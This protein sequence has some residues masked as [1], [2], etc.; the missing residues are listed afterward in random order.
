MP[1]ISFDI[2]ELEKEQKEILAKEFSESASRVTALPVDMFYVLFNERKADNVG[3]GGV[4]LSNQ[5]F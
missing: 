1:V 2:V 3:V 5:E 4:L